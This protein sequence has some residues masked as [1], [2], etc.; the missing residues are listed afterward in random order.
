LAGGNA[1]NR[2]YQ[3]LRKENKEIFMPLLS[4][5]GELLLPMAKLI[6]ALGT[7]SRKHLTN[8]DEPYT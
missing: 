1:R 7:L 6:E 3:I 5:S 4:D 8:I 2:V